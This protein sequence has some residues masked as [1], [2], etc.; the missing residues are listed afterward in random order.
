MCDI[1]LSTEERFHASQ[2]SQVKSTL[3][4][5]SSTQFIL[6]VMFLTEVYDGYP[7]DVFP[8]HVQGICSSWVTGEERRMMR[9]KRRGGERRRGDRREG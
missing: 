7:L 9:E 1:A 4:H 8:V 5:P 2:T 6:R 3:P